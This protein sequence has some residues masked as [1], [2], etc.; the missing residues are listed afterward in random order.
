M[1]RGANPSDRLSDRQRTD[2]ISQ[3]GPNA[4]VRRL[5]AGTRPIIAIH[6]YQ[7]EAAVTLEYRIDVS[8]PKLLGPPHGLLSLLGFLYNIRQ[9]HNISTIGSCKCAFDWHQ[10]DRWPRMSEFSRNFVWFVSQIWEATKPTTATRMKIDPHCQNVSDGIVAHLM[11]FS[12][13]YRLHW[14]CWTFFC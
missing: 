4:W 8:K 7:K 12:A 9:I 10:E 11:Y 2:R 13:M 14:Y 5:L 3:L 6:Y 1:G